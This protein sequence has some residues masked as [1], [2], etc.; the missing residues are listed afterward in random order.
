MS[1]PTVDDGFGCEDRVSV[2]GAHLSFD[3]C[4]GVRPSLDCGWWR[5]FQRCSALPFLCFLYR[6][7]CGAVRRCRGPR[8]FMAPD[9]S[10]EGR[11][12][13]SLEPAPAP[14]RAGRVGLDRRALAPLMR[15]AYRAARLRL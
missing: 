4:C 6:W 10:G 11:A 9:M 12:K 3:G 2:T 5:A 14:D 8:D 1:A 13:R 15:P 7:C